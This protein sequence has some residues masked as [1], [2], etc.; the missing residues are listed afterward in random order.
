MKRGS[1]LHQRQSEICSEEAVVVRAGVARRG[2]D[3]LGHLG[4]GCGAAG[5]QPALGADD[6]GGLLVLARRLALATPGEPALD[7]VEKKCA[8]SC[9]KLSEKV[10]RLSVGE[11][12]EGEEQT[13]VITNSKI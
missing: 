5:V 3:D 11:R 6:G 13:S 4:A 9:P 7:R 10:M 12:C 1:S 2:G 8:E